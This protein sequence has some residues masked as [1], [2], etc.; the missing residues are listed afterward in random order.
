MRARFRAWHCFSRSSS[1]WLSAE[2]R[3]RRA[4]SGRGESD[5]ES[6]RGEALRGA[7][8]TLE[9]P[10]VGALKVLLCVQLSLVSSLRTLAS[11]RMLKASAQRSAT[12]WP[13]PAS[14]A[15]FVGLM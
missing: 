1:R 11:A 5:E 8:V 13:S 14:A 2:A 9:G 4:L 6:L 7:R 12:V 3:C 10:V 15:G